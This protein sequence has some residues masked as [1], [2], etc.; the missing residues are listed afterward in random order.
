MLLLS[1]IIE[2]FYYQM[3]CNFTMYNVFFPDK[4]VY[5][6]LELVSYIRSKFIPKFSKNLARRIL[7]SFKIGKLCNKIYTHGNYRIQ[8]L[9]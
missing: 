1:L 5:I 2:C 8:Q 7:N 9:T 4:V 6:K 3:Q